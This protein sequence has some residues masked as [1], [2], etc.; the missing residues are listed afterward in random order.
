MPTRHHVEIAL[1]ELLGMQELGYAVGDFH[2]A[3]KEGYS[4]AISRLYII[5]KNA[6]NLV[7]VAYR[8]KPDIIY[9]NSRLEVL[10]G[11]R[12]FI[13]ILILK[14][15]YWRKVKTVIKSH[16]SDLTVINTSSFAIKSIVLPFLKKNVSAWLFLS[17]EE[18]AHIIQSGFLP[19]KRVFVAKNIVRTDQFK[20]TPEFRIKHSIAEKTKILLFVGRIIREKGIYEVL[21]AFM[22]LYT[23]EPI[24][25]IVVGDGAEYE[26]V[27][28]IYIGPDENKRIIFTGFIPEQEVVSYYANSDMLVFPTY[29]P[30]GFPMALFNSVAAGLSIVTTAIRAASDHL[31]EPE[32]CLWVKPQNSNSVADAI[33]RILRSKVL[34][35][36]MRANNLKKAKLFSRSQIAFELSNIF[37]QLV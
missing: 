19:A 32:N 21:E 15:F 29:F 4:S 18:K 36:S 17:Q 20:P 30:E 9:F 34:E 6:F 14:V 24:I 16:G 26:N 37:N 25:L 12:D 5:V 3:A 7:R 2:Y 13:T 8:F 35:S 23:E 10:A 31:T 33:S 28:R 1:D 22:K 11:I 27:R